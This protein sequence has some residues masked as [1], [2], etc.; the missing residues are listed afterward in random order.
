LLVSASARSWYDASMK[1]A[2]KI[3]LVGLGILGVIGLPAFLM[4]G[5]VWAFVPGSTKLTA[6]DRKRLEQMRQEDAARRAA[7][8]QV[9]MPAPDGSGRLVPVVSGRLVPVVSAGNPRGHYG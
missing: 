2:G 9:M 7:S 4:T 8:P 3:A 6:E 5:N 1:P